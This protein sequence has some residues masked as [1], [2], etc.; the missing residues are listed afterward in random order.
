M[1]NIVKGG[2]MAGLVVYLCGPGRAN[3]HTEP[4]LVGGDGLLLD[5]Y[6]DAELNRQSALAI[7]GYLDK[8]RR[9]SGTEITAPA[10]DASGNVVGRKAAHVWHCSLALEPG[11]GPLADGQWQAISTDFMNEMGF[12]EIGSGR[13]AARWAAIHHGLTKAG[14]DHIHIA[15]SLVREDG[16]KVSTHN[17]QLR[18]QKICNELER[19]YGL[20][21]LLSRENGTGMP[22]L[23]P[24]EVQRAARLGLPEPERLTIARTVRACA[25][26]ARTEA[27]FV[28][29]CRQEGL[30]LRARFADG[31]SDVVVGYSVGLHPV[32]GER[33][34]YY[35]GSGLAKDLALP[36]LR[37][38]WEISPDLATEAVAEWTAAKRGQRI[39]RQAPGKGGVSPRT[40][41]RQAAEVASLREQLRAVPADDRHT[42][43]VVARQSAGV[44][45]A[46]SRRT[47]SEPGPLAATADALARSAQMHYRS[48]RPKYTPAP[49]LS[50][51][52][53][54]LMQVAGT[55]N[56]VV[57][58]LVLVR[59]L[60]NT[61][62]AVHDAHVARGE[63]KQALILENA[64]KG[65]LAQF[66]ESLPQP[67]PGD[68]ATAATVPGAGVVPSRAA[69]LSGD[70]PLSA[71]LQLASATV[72]SAV[73]SDE[74]A[75][76]PSDPAW[77]ALA[78][79]IADLADDG[80]DPIATVHA[81]YVM[82]D[83]GDAESA[84]QVMTWRID[85]LVREGAAPVARAVHD[86][87]IS[88][89]LDA[90]KA[91]SGSAPQRAVASS[92]PDESASPGADQPARVAA[93]G[94]Q[95]STPSSTDTEIGD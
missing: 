77:P 48:P 85:R 49:A 30:L 82:R 90:L 26:G 39:R 3:E 76:W 21:V 24:A 16:T 57:A 52:A 91:M 58:D 37:E 61:M 67:A 35:R 94:P 9:I 4:H 56:S 40:W 45:A 44:F 20:R 55:R 32:G 2:R 50:G 46:W 14:G 28:R 18:A 79:R 59:Q 12:T 72:S 73:G 89:A 7:A 25:A 23:K 83:F 15:A 5:V 92:P 66:M 54:L 86:P 41:E 19:K 53:V 78:A 29:A 84:V 74:A 75:Q 27:E 6:K 81:A 70:E 63:L 69:A 1:P 34:L 10:R 43:A 62:K 11:E 95:A 31:R 33:P 93:A 22:G 51:T 38:H 8:P 71:E 47:E 36:R 80:L 60:A 64:A 42:W 88:A 65:Q 68:P 17:D 87:E 13:S